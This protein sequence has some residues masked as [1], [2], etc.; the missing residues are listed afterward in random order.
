M[1]TMAL[2]VFALCLFG[3]S[4]ASVA[5]EDSLEIKASS[6]SVLYRSGFRSSPNPLWL[7]GDKDYG[8]CFLVFEPSREFYRNL[9]GVD[10]VLRSANVADAESEEGFAVIAAGRLAARSGVIGRNQDIV[11]PL[12]IKALGDAAP[13]TLILVP[14]GTDGVGLLPQAKLRASRGVAKSAGN[15]LVAEYRFDGDA[16]DSSG[17]GNH[18]IAAGRCEFGADRLG[19]ARGALRI[20]GDKKAIVTVPHG[21]ALD[22]GR[23]TLAAWVKGERP[24]LWAR[25]LHKFNFRDKAGYALFYDHKKGALA[26][27]AYGRENK[28]LW[29]ASRAK[30]SGDW[31]H[32]AFTYDGR[33]GCL[34]IN[35]QP[36]SSMELPMTLKP[37]GGPLSIGNGFDGYEYYPWSGLID[38]V[39]IYDR[40]LSP[41]DVAALF[42]GKASASASSNRL[43]DLRNV[44]SL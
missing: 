43:P 30:L 38:E 19:R 22:P 23:M 40:A 13:L 31:Q 24:Q 12:N 7:D 36:D 42:E 6:I 25:I 33:T 11:L 41:A 27:E 35:G 37:Y 20:A 18:G 2:S 21:A 3:F 26:F 1:K 9:E 16:L 5:A 8:V 17:A 4:V 28:R 15:G 39:R 14:N 32:V 10:L 44:N 34:F 29:L